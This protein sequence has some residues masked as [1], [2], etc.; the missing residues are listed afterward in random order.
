MRSYDR[1]EMKE[2]TPSQKRALAIVTGVALLFGAYFL[3]RY[4]M[5]IVIAAI[6]AY[7]F[8]PL[9]NKLRARLNGGL[10][11]TLTVLAA[12]ATV[13]ITPP[14]LFW[15]PEWKAVLVT[16]GIVLVY[17]GLSFII[18]P[19]VDR[20]TLDWRPGSL[21]T[22]PAANINRLLAIAH[23]LLAPGRFAAETLLD[24]CV[25]AGVARE[26]QPGGEPPA[27]ASAIGSPQQHSTYSR[28]S[29]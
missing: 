23:W 25:L 10:A 17:F 4:F 24:L 9:Y 20:D 29:H 21:A 27:S 8:A 5:L 6:V 28:A 7:L 16:F 19:Q 13:V 26:T 18:R 12:L 2:F 14:L 11:T 15:M 3:R 22:E 1:S